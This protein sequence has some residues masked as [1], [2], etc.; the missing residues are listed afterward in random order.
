MEDNKKAACLSPASFCFLTLRHIIFAAN[1]MQV[2]KGG[3]TEPV[4]NQKQ[5][6]ETNKERECKKK[7]SNS[8]FVHHHGIL[9]SLQCQHTH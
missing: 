8:N 7:L 2:I 4:N 5:I 6:S 1:K 9:Y 3:K